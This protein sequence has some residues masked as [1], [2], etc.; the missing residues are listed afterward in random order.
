MASKHREII[1]RLNGSF[2]EDLLSKHFIDRM[3]VE[4]ADQ[5]HV[6]NTMEFNPFRDMEPF[7]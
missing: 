3:K 6:I 4:A 5:H 7:D 2:R 1:Q